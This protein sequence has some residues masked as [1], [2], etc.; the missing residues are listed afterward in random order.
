RSIDSIICPDSA[1][2]VVNE[3]GAPT[4][5]TGC[6][7]I[8]L[9]ASDGKVTPEQIR[10][11]HEDESWWGMHATRPRLVSI[12]QS[13][14]WGTVFTLEELSA[15]KGVCQELGVRL[16]VDG[17][18]LYNAAAALDCSLADLCQHV[19]ILS[20]GGTKNGLMFGEA[21]VFFDPQAADGFLHVRKQGLQLNSKMRFVSAQF[22]ALFTDQLWKKNAAHA[23]RMAKL[24]AE[25][26]EPCEGITM[27]CPVQTNQIFL[28]MPGPLAEALRK[29]ADFYPNGPLPQS[30][31]M[32]TSFDTTEEDVGRLV[33]QA[34]ALCQ[35]KRG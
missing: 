24:L 34:Q 23:N 15:I 32:V 26:L 35:Q 6:K 7:M 31:R 29:V 21:V 20:L 25:G 19:D 14:E 13:T 17:C 2:I 18:R 11:A 30:Y 10:R 22:K 27:N 16:H 28:S 8:S 12:S 1:H 4:S 3:V 5:A 33:Q 9:P